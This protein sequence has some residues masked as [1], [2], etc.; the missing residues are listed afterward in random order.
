MEPGNVME[1]TFGLHQI[2]CAKVRLGL[3]TCSPL[4]AWE[5]D[6]YYKP[7]QFMAIHHGRENTGLKLKVTA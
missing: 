5:I 6:P 2:R 1:K 7:V 4:L 3:I